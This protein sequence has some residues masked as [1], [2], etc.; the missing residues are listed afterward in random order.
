MSICKKE[1]IV[2]TNGMKSQKSLIETVGYA[3]NS[4]AEL[5][6]ETPEDPVEY[7]IVIP[8]LNEEQSIFPLYEKISKVMGSISE[9]YE[10]IFIDDGST[11]RTFNAMRQLRQNNKRVRAIRFGRNFGKS[12][13]LT[14][15]Y[16][17]AKGN[18]IIMMDGD[19]QNDPEDIPRFLAKIQ[20][21]FD[22]VNGW[23]FERKDPTVRKNVPSRFQNRLNRWLT[24]VPVH[25]SVCGF[26]AFRREVAKSLRLYGE[27]HRYIPA[28]VYMNGYSIGEIKIIH[29]PRQYGKSKYGASRLI[30]GFL[31]LMFINFWLQYS[32]RPL[33]FF[34]SLGLV[35]ILIGFLIAVYK[36]F[37]Q[38]LYLGETLIVGPQLLLASLL[39]I[40]GTLFIMFGFLSEILVRT[41]YASADQKNY[42]I[43]EKLG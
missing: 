23:R 26:K 35:Q 3:S 30:K 11:D 42:F 36:V 38:R 10:V 32:S 28:L 33:H 12:A 31:D 1:L 7:S 4:M 21:G 6:Q 15:G 22:M 2:G 13:A 5:D 20:E 37:Y 18:I 43:R 40:L 41:F 24:G 34:G 25:D 8:V 14:A 39:L 9:K 27:T 17:E 19:L 16:D 29:H